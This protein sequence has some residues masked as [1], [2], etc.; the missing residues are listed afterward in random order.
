MSENSVSMR[1]LF[2]YPLC[3]NKINK[4]K[5]TSQYNDKYCRQARKDEKLRDFQSF[6]AFY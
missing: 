6:G 4:H 1:T 3:Y 5:N 2:W